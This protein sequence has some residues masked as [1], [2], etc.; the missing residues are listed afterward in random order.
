MPL[1]KIT[2]AINGYGRIGRSIL[3][4]IY[5]SGLSHS[6]K[7]AAIN[8][9]ADGKTIAHLTKYDS[10]HG[11]FPGEVSYTN[12]RLRI[13]DDSIRILHE[14]SV[15]KLPWRQLGIHRWKPLEEEELVR[16]KGDEIL[17]R[18]QTEN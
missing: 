8:E 16:K 4:A 18:H 10:T 14:S 6:I 3:R 1:S 12:D 11:R 5:E 17:V 15:L 9:L 7:I 2:V 13:H